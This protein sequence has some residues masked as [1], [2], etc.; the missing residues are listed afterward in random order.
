MVVRRAIIG[1]VR[2]TV[3]T[4]SLV[5]LAALALCGC[6]ASVS[7][8]ADAISATKLA[9]A[10]DG[11]LQDIKA[12]N[13]EVGDVSCDGALEP[14]NDAEQ[15]CHFT[16]VAGDRYGV[17]VTVTGIDGDDLS[18]DLDA[19]PGQTVE[20]DELEPE[21]TTQ[22]TDLSGG[23]A[24]DAVDC[25]DDLPGRVDATTTCILTAGEDRIETTVTVTSA[26]GPD[27]A[28]DIDVASEPLP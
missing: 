25:P 2:P 1:Q 14:E 27:V 9:D 17:T 5:L 24:P 16:D 23:V 13:A 21:V 3:P 15:R 28:F 11:K 18:Y 22:L 26:K 6:S 7:S 4:R 10:V 19:D 20:P 12:D 8:G